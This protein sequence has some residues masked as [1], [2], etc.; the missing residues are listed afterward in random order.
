MT[1][2]IFNF[3]LVRT[4]SDLLVSMVRSSLACVSYVI[5]MSVTSMSGSG[6]YLYHFSSTFFVKIGH[7]DTLCGY[8]QDELDRVYISDH[9][10]SSLSLTSYRVATI[11]TIFKFIANDAIIHEA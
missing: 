7:P 9:C 11:E 2:H 3:L 1:V 10:R 4:M 5:V 6:L 8:F